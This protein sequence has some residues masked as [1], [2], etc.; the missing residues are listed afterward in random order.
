MV[1][2]LR[3]A[4]VGSYNFA[5]HS[6]NATNKA[7]QAVEKILDQ[8]IDIHWL[9]ET[10][11]CETNKEELYQKYDG[12]FIAPGP[13]HKPFYFNSVFKILESFDKPVLGTGE[14]FKLFIAYYFKNKGLDNE[15]VISDNLINSN[16]FA[17][18][19]LEKFSSECEKIY[20]NRG[21]VEYSSSRYSILPQYSDI[22]A[23]DYE[24]GA[25]N[26][27]FDPEIIKHKAHPFFMFTMFCPQMNSTEDI[28]HP[29]IT[30]FIKT[31]IRISDIK[32]TEM[33]K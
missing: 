10:E 31:A 22:L 5:Y 2:R 1:K 19:N 29:L 20:I 18:V 15:K 24:I 33:Q 9:N 4:I 8:P 3:I 27:F 16:K 32:E 17:Q 7:M 21:A 6:H 13:Y 26:Q 23:E 25:R 12:F 11:F 30:Y 14:V 28:P